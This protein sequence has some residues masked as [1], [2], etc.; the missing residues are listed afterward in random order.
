MNSTA[1]SISQIASLVQSQVSNPNSTLNQALPP[2]TL[3]TLFTPLVE[4]K[5]QCSDGQWRA[6]CN[7]PPTPSPSAPAATSSD[8]VFSMSLGMFIIVGTCALIVL[9]AIGYALHICWNRRKAQRFV[10]FGEDTAS[11]VPMSDL[12]LP[13][14][15][16]SHPAHPPATDIWDTKYLLARR[17]TDNDDRFSRTSSFSS[18]ISELSVLPPTILN[19]IV[20]VESSLSARASNSLLAADASAVDS[21]LPAWTPNSLLAADVSAVDSGLSAW[22]PNSLLAADASTVESSLPAWTPNS[23]LAAHAPKYI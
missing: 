22:T 3:D 10:E 15:I 1:L 16:S 17:L 14:T 2:G 23:L 9:F 20:S 11:S 21:G 12:A 5:V 8:S 18:S 4:V 6:A 7:A 19:K 13:P